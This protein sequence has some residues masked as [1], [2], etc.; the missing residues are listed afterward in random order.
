VPLWLI[1]RSKL[2]YGRL[3]SCQPK[4]AKDSA[5]GLDWT[6]KKCLLRSQIPWLLLGFVGFRLARI[7]P[8]APVSK[9]NLATGALSN[10]RKANSNRHPPAKG[11]ALSE[12]KSIHLELLF[13]ALSIC[14]GKTSAKPMSHS[15]ISLK[16]SRFR[17]NTIAVP[18]RHLVGVAV[19]VLPGG[20][21]DSG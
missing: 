16:C 17:G 2:I 3:S 15:C 12:K 13:Q 4:P 18:S 10:L 1:H 6:P 21:M 11:T 8:V 14:N 9:S 5:C 19:P 7:Q 20:Q